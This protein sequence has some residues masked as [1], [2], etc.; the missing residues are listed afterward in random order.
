MCSGGRHDRIYWGLQRERGQMRSEEGSRLWR[1]KDRDAFTGGSRFGGGQK[2]ELVADGRVTLPSDK[3][4]G[5]GRGCGG[6]PIWG[7]KLEAGSIKVAFKPGDLRA[8]SDGVR[9]RP[10][11]LQRVPGPTA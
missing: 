11:G 5:G 6:G 7:Q 8:A 1:R 10:S 9:R 2:Q 3:P 4:C